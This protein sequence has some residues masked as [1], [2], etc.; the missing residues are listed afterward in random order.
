MSLNNNQ[1]DKW[2]FMSLMG[3]NGIC[4]RLIHMYLAL[5]NN[6]KDMSGN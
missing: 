1:W 6:N 3:F 2:V 4:L 5:A